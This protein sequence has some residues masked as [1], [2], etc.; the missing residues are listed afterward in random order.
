MQVTVLGGCDRL[1]HVIAMDLSA[2]LDALFQLP[3]NEFTGARN[4]LA[5]RLQKAGRKEEADHVRRL[6]KPPVSAWV[7][8]QL[9]WKEP[10]GSTV[11]WRPERS[12]RQAQAAGLA[13]QAGQRSRSVEGAA[14]G[15]ERAV[16]A[17]R[18]VPVAGRSRAKP[19]RAAPRDPRP[20]RDWP[21]RGGLPTGPPRAPHLRRGGDGLRCAGGSGAP[22]SATVVTRRH[23][24]QQGAV[25][26][27]QPASRPAQEV[28]RGGA[29]TTERSRERERAQA[30]AARRAVQD[31]ERALA[32]AR[33][34]AAKA[35][36]AMKAAAARLKES[37]R[38]KAKV[39]AALEKARPPPT[40]RVRPR[41]A[42]Q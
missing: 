31:A 11:C 40:R 13:G 35:E 30:A 9:F 37:E 21:R 2:D 7:V 29:A 18:G 12:S 27:V 28:R 36:A 32:A 41:G 19:G 17:S 24:H 33:R 25:V 42:R 3:L 38:E 4:A 22:E 14:R 5:S 39:E 8:N 20:R 16:A 23:R 26:R 34:D 6:T 1:G 15:A 10:P